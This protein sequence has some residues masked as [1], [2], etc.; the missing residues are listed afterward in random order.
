MWLLGN[1][2]QY[3][4]SATLIGFGFFAAL[5][6]F[7][8]PH[9]TKAVVP[10]TCPNPCETWD[11]ALSGDSNF[12]G[13]IL[14]FSSA[15]ESEVESAGLLDTLFGGSNKG[16]YLGKEAGDFM[17]T[18]SNP[19]G[20]LLNFFKNTFSWD[21][22]SWKLGRKVVHQ[23]SQA[24]VKWIRTG[25]DPFFFGGTSGSLFVT[26]IDTF[27]LDAA[28]NAAS[29]FLSEYYGDETWN[30]L[31]TP[32]RLQIGLGL[33]RSYGRDFGSF[34]NQATCTLQDIVA[35]VEDFYNN[36]ENG[37][38]EAWISSASYS[39]D[40]WRLLTL[41]QE[42][43]RSRQ[44]RASSANLYDF[45]AGAGFPG[46]RECV[47]GINAKGVLVEYPPMEAGMTCEK[48]LTKTPGDAIN[49][50]L[51]EVLKA[52]L[53]KL[54]LADEL[55][56]IVAALFDKTLSWILGGGSGKKGVL[57]STN[58]PDFDDDPKPGICSPSTG[59]P[60]GCQCTLDTQC[61]SNFCS[62]TTRT[63]AAPKGP[64]DPL[65]NPVPPPKTL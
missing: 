23:F 61:A 8:V 45:I 28:D 15:S 39:N 2:A 16:W 64:P 59:R 7:S 38:W 40:P 60:N 37:G 32:F 63:C 22:L 33:S 30:Q 29:G 54:K 47:L 46:L 42:T 18:L 27:L 9:T 6:I 53:D 25:Q 50:T 4:L 56:E 49:D 3:G 31:C 52:D 17:S 55:N 41:G 13:G 11:V 12:L 43:S 5:I 65:P 1:K 36:F 48:Y 62:P 24:T 19:F 35:N 34:K 10:V 57:G 51:E 44:S 21:S 20:A 58:L 26:N 14:P